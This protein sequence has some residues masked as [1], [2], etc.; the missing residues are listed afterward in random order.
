MNIYKE[1]KKLASLNAKREHLIET[2]NKKYGDL[3]RA[4]IGIRRSS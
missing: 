2:I 3:G 4:S 1:I